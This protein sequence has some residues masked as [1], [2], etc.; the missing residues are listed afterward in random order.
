MKLLDLC[1]R[2]LYPQ[3]CHFCGKINPEPICKSCKEKVFY[4]REPRCKKC[5]K[6]IR[7]QE[8]EFC[9]DCSRKKKS[10]ETGR[11]LWVHKGPVTWSIYQFKYHN[12]R[13]YGEFYAKELYR[14]YGK[15]IKLWGI[16][17]I[18]PVP[19]HPKRKRIRGYNQAEIVARHLGKLSGLPVETKWV[20]RTR[21]TKP[22]KSLNNLERKKNLEEAFEVTRNFE[23]YQNVLIIDDIYTTGSTIDTIAKQ[24]LEKCNKK[25]WFFT[26]SIGQDF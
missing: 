11:S 4:I 13:I 5:G 6:P 14:L 3:T 25:V 18:V 17:V 21:Y 24:L 1:L 7:Y 16:D 23:Q 26:I 8:Q 2:M 10:F 9:M 19:V 22:Q 12:R 20:K 15:D